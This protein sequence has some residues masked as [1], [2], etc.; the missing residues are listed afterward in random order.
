MATHLSNREPELTRLPDLV[1][2][3]YANILPQFLY[4]PEL[5]ASFFQ[6]RTRGGAYVPLAFRTK[7]GVVGIVPTCRH[8]VFGI[9]AS[10]KYS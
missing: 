5:T 8:R 6:Y 4:R 7:K 1:R 3:L 10:E 2:G 9:R